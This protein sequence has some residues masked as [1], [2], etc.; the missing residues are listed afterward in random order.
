MG[1]GRV[2]LN[3][4]SFLISDGHDVIIIESDENLCNEAVNEL[5]ALVICGNG[6]EAK[7]LNEANIKDADVFVA[8]TGN[9]EVNLFACILVKKY[10]V[11]RKAGL[12]SFVILE[13]DGKFLLFQETGILEEGKGYSESK[14]VGFFNKQ[15]KHCNGFF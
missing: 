14:L 4:S 6:I 5:D 12:P 13:N 2:G 9:D 1:A 7:I 10:N 8:A 3:L 15:R 11:Q